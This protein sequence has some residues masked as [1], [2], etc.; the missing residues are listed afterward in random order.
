MHIKYMLLDKGKEEGDIQ[1]VTNETEFI[2][3]S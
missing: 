1:T 2:F 3:V